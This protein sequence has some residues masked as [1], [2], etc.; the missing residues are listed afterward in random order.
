MSINTNKKRAATAPELQNYKESPIKLKYP[1]H[2]SHLAP[3]LTEQQ[4][5]FQLNNI[6][7][8]IAAAIV[9]TIGGELP[10][11]YLD[12]EFEDIESDDEYIMPEELIMRMR[13]I[14]IAQSLPIGAKFGLDFTNKSPIIVNVKTKELKSNAAVAIPFNQNITIWGLSR[15]KT[16]KMQLRVAESYSYIEGYGGLSLAVQC[17]AIPTDMQ[18]YDVHTRTGTPNAIANPRNFQFRFLTHGTM[19]PREILLRSF[20]NLIVRIQ[21]VTEFIPIKLVDK[22]ISIYK[23]IGDS[24]TIGTLLEKTIVE[25]FP[26]IGSIAF[27]M[28]ADIVTLRLLSADDDADEI[29]HKAIDLLITEFQLIKKLF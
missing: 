12:C 19:P 5:E 29:M 14:P 6:N 27:N 23:I 8:A 16:L 10:V 4:C 7:N 15:A 21:R 24:A 11:K 9:R 26:T 18:P 2:L 22:D 1:A 17:V 28:D 13:M 25:N 3:Q 20:D